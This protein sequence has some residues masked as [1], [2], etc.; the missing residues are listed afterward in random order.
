MITTKWRIS[1][2]V[3]YT[4][5]RKQYGKNAANAFTSWFKVKRYW[6]GRLVYVSVRHFSLCFDFRKN[7]LLDMVDDE[8]LDKRQ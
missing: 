6:G 2:R 4:N 5:Y 1:P 8:R 3:S 7:W